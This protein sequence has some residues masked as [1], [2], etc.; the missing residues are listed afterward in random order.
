MVCCFPNHITKQA[1]FTLSK[2]RKKYNRLCLITFLLITLL[3]I[4]GV[5]V[6]R[7]LVAAIRQWQLRR[8]ADAYDHEEERSENEGENCNCALCY[9]NIRTI[10][11]KPCR[12][13]A[14]CRYCY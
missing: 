8:Q 4:T 11:F 3:S 10:I 7:K 13:Y 2:L 6:V 12:H 5:K 1:S 9:V 14:I